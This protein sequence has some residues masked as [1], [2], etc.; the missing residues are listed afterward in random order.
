MFVT[1]GDISN[2]ESCY[3]S[4]TVLNGL[5]DMNTFNFK[6][7]PQAKQPFIFSIAWNQ[8]GNVR[9]YFLEIFLLYKFVINFMLILIISLDFC[10]NFL[11]SMIALLVSLS[12]GEQPINLLIITLLTLILVKT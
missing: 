5:R 9:H 6:N 4:S 7:N 11:R 12:P 10:S 3:Y 1:S 8:V 2:P